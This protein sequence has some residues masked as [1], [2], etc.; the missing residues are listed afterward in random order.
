MS[1]PTA[2][3]SRARAL[4]QEGLGAIGATDEARP[5]GVGRMSERDRCAVHEELPAARPRGPREHVEE[6][7]LALALQ[8]DDAEHLARVQIEGGVL[9]LRAGAD[10]AGRQAWCGVRRARAGCRAVGAGLREV[11]G[12]P[13]EH[14]FDDAVLRARRDVDDADGDS[15]AEDG[16]G[17]TGDLDNAVGSEEDRRSPPR[18][19]PITSR[20]RSVR[21]AGRAAD[22]SSSMRT[23]GSMARARARS[24]IRSEARG[25]RRAIA[26]RSRSGSPSSPSQCRNG[27]SG[28]S[29]R[30][31]LD[32]MS[33]SGISA[34]SW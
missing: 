24:T 12:L 14:Q 10:R 11:R 7:V 31:R 8:R 4:H 30:R 17:P 28:V 33:R 19:R 3:H 16:G 13:A 15:L 2:G 29:V 34:G 5:Y 26:D 6:L 9:Q 18:R 20:T 21:S 1:P 23:S 32:R 22:I 25:T 27:S